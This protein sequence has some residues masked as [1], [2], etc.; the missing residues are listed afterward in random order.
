MKKHCIFLLLIACIFSSYS[1]F[2]QSNEIRIKFI[3]NC[4]LYMTDGNLNVY[5]DFPYK[6]GAY[7]YMEY[8]RSE[9]DSINDNSVFIFTHRHADH[10][11]RKLLKRLNGK[12]HGPWKVTKKR[13]L[14]PAQLSDSVK[15]FSL[16]AFKTSHKFSFKHNSYLLTWHNKKIFIT[17]DTEDA[18]PLSKAGRLDWVFAPFWIYTNAKEEQVTINTEMRG[19]YHLYPHQTIG[20]GFPPDMI[21]LKEQNRV[22]SIPY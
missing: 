21:F 3:G 16:Q 9:L 22:I 12:V 17:G 18:E 5:V 10:Y 19:V 6:S 13:R 8:S 1:G 2:S 11:S 20:E 14:D 7:N 4:G 15:D